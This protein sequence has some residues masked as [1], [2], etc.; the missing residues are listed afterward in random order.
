MEFLWIHWFGRDPDHEG[1]FK[2]RHLHRIGL[3]DS[4]DPISY[5]FLNPHDVI[6]SIHLIPVF[7]SNQA[8]QEANDEDNDTPSP[9]LYYVSMYMIHGSSFIRTDIDTY[10]VCRSQYVHALSRGWDWSQIY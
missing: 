10:Q 5:E 1:G 6:R 4:K 2:T 3:I 7:S 8:D 9:D